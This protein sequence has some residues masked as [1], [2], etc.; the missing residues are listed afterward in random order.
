MAI[1]DW[2][3]QWSLSPLEAL[4]PRW[5]YF[6]A[7]YR[8]DFENMYK[9]YSHFT[10]E[11]PLYSKSRSKPYT[12]SDPTRLLNLQNVLTKI[13]FSTQRDFMVAIIFSQSASS[14]LLGQDGRLELKPT[15]RLNDHPESIVVNAIK[16]CDLSFVF[17][18]V[19]QQLPHPSVDD[20]PRV[21]KPNDPGIL[22]ARVRDHAKEVG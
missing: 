14:L 12:L 4:R 1:F 19:R 7:G 20:F 10:I 8:Y 22:V 13:K 16:N 3:E 21:A 9:E 15:Y 6:P 18:L 5:L 2:A 11:Y 17:K